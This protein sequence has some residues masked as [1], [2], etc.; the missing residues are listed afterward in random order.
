MKKI[1][2]VVLLITLTMSCVTKISNL[3]SNPGKYAGNSVKISGVVTKLVKVPFTEY[4]F[5][6]LTD[7][8]DNILIFSLNE[9]KKG[10]NTTISAKVIGYS[11][12]DQQQSTLLV[13]GSIE[14]FL[15]DSGIF[16]E[17]NVTK[18]AKKIGETISKALA[19]MDATYFLIEDN[20]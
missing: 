15:L 12:E 1:V 18:P 11:S 13:I 2:I 20:L 14:Q 10:Q 9:H 4:T 5:L 16:N 7:K 8:S 3:K 17:E 19:A 6:E